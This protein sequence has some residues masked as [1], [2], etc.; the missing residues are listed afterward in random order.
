MMGATAKPMEAAMRTRSWILPLLLLCFGL[1]FAGAHAQTQQIAVGEVTEDRYPQQSPAQQNVVFARGVVGIPGVVYSTGAGTVPLRLDLYLPPGPAATP[2][3]VV[4]YIHGGEWVGGSRRASGAF[5]DWPQALAS[6]AARGFVVASIDY[7]LAPGA[8]FPA[9]IIDVKDALRWLRSKAGVYGIDRARV[10]VWGADAGG[11]LAALA[12]LSCGAAGLDRAA[13][14]GPGAGAAESACAQAA[15]V[16]YGVGDF[17]PLREMRAANAYFLGCQPQAN[18]APQRR[19]ASPVSHIDQNTPPF[20]II[21]GMTDLTFAVSQA[22]ELNDRI[23]A[24]GGSVELVLLPD[25][26]HG[27]VGQTP[28]ATRDASQR[29]WDRTVDFIVRMVGRR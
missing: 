18:C 25:V 29:A 21:H 1:P 15:V 4:V 27:F 16:W 13:A 17:G 19:L 2:R 20:L 22:K 5:A 3:P 11:Q 23:K 14:A 24:A 9:A 12:A 8:T 6:L 26:G 10:L 7:R 28:A